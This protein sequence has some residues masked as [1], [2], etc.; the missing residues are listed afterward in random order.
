[1]A[2]LLNAKSHIVPKSKSDIWSRVCDV[3]NKSFTTIYINP[4]DIYVNV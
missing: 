3:I 4:F 1:M 2:L